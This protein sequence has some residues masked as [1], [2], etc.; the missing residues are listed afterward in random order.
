MAHPHDDR[1]HQPHNRLPAALP[2]N[3]YTALAPHVE[4]VT[5]SVKEPVYEP[6]LCRLHPA[7]VM[8][9][10]AQAVHDTT[11]IAGDQHRGRGWCTS[12]VD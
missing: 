2:A 12:G 5:L 4:P 1:P 8:R 7:S 6:N 10:S 3:G 11:D 9:Q